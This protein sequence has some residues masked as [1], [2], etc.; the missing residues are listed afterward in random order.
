MIFLFI[1]LSLKTHVQLYVRL[2]LTLNCFPGRANGF[3]T[4]EVG[5]VGFRTRMAVPK[6][7]GEVLMLLVFALLLVLMAAWAVSSRMRMQ[8]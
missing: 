4:V 5:Y 1:F 2:L 3:S 7:V 6:L 8:S